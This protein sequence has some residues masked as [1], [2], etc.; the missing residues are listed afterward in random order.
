[1]DLAEHQVQSR[2]G[3]EQSSNETL[4]VLPST[5]LSRPKRQRRAPTSPPDATSLS[6]DFVLSALS[7]CVYAFDL[8]GR[9]TYANEAALRAWK[10]DLARAVGKTPFD[11]GYPEDVA[12]RMEAEIS[13]VSRTGSPVRG[14]ACFGSPSAFAVFEYMLSPIAGSNGRIR[15]VACTARDV[16]EQRRIQHEA[17]AQLVAA[18]AELEE[19]RKGEER[20]AR[21]NDRLQRAMIETHHRVKNN[22]QIISALVEVQMEDGA[23]TVPVSALARIGRHTRSL[24]ALH[25]LLTRETKVGSPGDS[26]SAKSMMDKLLPLLRA[27]AVTRTIRYEGDDFPVTVSQ[28]ASL[29]LLVSELVGNAVKHGRGDVD[30]TLSARSPLAWL[31]VSDD[32]D[33]FPADFDPRAAAGTGLSLIDSAGRYDLNGTVTYENRTPVGARVVVC[34]PIP[35]IS[36]PA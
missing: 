32:G 11:L 6:A 26:L 8:C 12:V 29:A 23:E 36:A 15:A 34:F 14:E 4:D 18:R 19:R 27:S 2:T 24:A 13:M 31:E 25:D 16:T 17:E 20:A 7:D 33:G 30:L 1:M 35:A 5:F 10:I 3:R 9:I 28:A 22:L 21:L